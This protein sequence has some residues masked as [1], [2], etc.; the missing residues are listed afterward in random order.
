MA[1]ADDDPSAL[2]RAAADHVG[3]T[4]LLAA[5]ADVVTRRAWP[6]LTGLF[7]TDAPVRVD[8][9]TAPARELVGP[10]ELGAFIGGAVE[11]FG[12]FELVILNAH[13][14]VPSID[15][16]DEAR[17][18]VLISE[19]RQDRD[20]AAWSTTYG[21]YQDRYRRTVHGWR[22][23]GRRYQSLA[24]TGSDRAFPFPALDTDP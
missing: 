19:I 16:P 15:A 23:A 1:G 3:I 20:G 7:V 9:V 13:V 10:E 18:R 4:R 6:E 22:F 12:F 21:V 24:R 5:Y 8:T 2:D 17:G 14:E 11:R